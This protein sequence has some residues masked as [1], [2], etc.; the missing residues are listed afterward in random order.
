LPTDTPAQI[1]GN[2][3]SPLHD[4]PTM[5]ALLGAANTDGSLTISTNYL[6]DLFSGE[7][8]T[9]RAIIRTNLDLQVQINQRHPDVLAYLADQTALDAD[10]DLVA[11][12]KKDQPPKI[13]AATAAILVQSKLMKAKDPLLK[14]PGQMTACAEGLHMITDGLAAFKEMDATNWAKVAASGNMLAGGFEILNTFIGGET[15]EETIVREIGNI[16]ILIGDLSTN[17]NYRFDRVDQSLTNIFYRF[18]QR[19]DK[20]DIGVD[21]LG[22]QTAY[23]R[24]NVD[25]IRSALL[26]AQT[27]LNR[28]ER[29]LATFEQLGV[30]RT[31][32]GNMTLGLG[33][34]DT[35]GG[36]M[37]YTNFTPNYVMLAAAFYDHAYKWA[38]EEP[39][40]LCASL[41]F[42]TAK[43]F[44]EFLSPGGG[45]TN[46]YAET[47]N[48]IVKCLGEPSPGLGLSSF[49]DQPAGL[50]RRRR[51]LAATGP[52]ES[53][54]IS[55][56]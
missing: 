9:Y 26:E 20:I 45:A 41:P 55:P 3:N 31:L 14:L 27:S 5:L 34:E 56:V 15:S 8:G 35:A 37:A 23:L 7:T 10:S 50:E 49:L 1:I 43:D 44:Y 32:D 47:L 11:S 4:N 29:N 12:V 51:R 28:I 13:A 17:M 25:Y 33:Y 30:R 54:L 24:E 18:E 39:L 52:R 22:R 2:T 36:P 16:K 53:R 46:V 21:E 40:S 48:Y 38:D 6:K 19:F 42:T